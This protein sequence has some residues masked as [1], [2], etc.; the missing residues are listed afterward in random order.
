MIF[1]IRDQV[2]KQNIFVHTNAIIK[3]LFNYAVRTHIKGTIYIEILIQ[4]YFFTF[5]SSKISIIML[6]ANN[7]KKKKGSSTY[8]TCK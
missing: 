8:D 1:L 2:L 6:I 4:I 3:I 7:P 5:W